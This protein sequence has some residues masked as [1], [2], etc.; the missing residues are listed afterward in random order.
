MLVWFPTAVSVSC[1]YVCRLYLWLSKRICINGFQ[2]THFTWFAT[3][4]VY[5]LWQYLYMVSNMIV[6]SFL[7]VYIYL[8]IYICIQM[9]IYSTHGNCIVSCG[10]IL[11][12]WV[13]I[14]KE[15]SILTKTHPF[16][17]MSADICVLLNLPIY[18]SR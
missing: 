8:H 13:Y 7:I 10:M 11:E 12:T 17:Y 5:G 2:N 14:E 9:Q 1:L 16:I 6:V 4:L 15:C 18:I 3:V